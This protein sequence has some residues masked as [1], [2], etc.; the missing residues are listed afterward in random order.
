MFHC[1][2]L[3][4]FDTLSVYRGFVVDQVARAPVPRAQQTCNDSLDMKNNY[5]TTQV[6]LSSKISK[7]DPIQLT[8]VTQLTQ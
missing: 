1:H 4:H 6:S 7:S 3:K 8:E 2:L 5:P